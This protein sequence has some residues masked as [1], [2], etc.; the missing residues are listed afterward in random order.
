MFQPVWR[1]HCPGKPSILMLLNPTQL[2]RKIVRW[3]VAVLGATLIL[4]LAAPAA[5]A[6]QSAMQSAEMDEVDSARG[7]PISSIEVAGN[8][9]ISREDVLAYLRERVGQPFSPES[10]AQDTRELWASGF[11]DDIEV[12]LDRSTAGVVLRFNVRERPNIKKVEFVGND[13]VS[14]EDLEEGVELKADTILSQPAIARSIQKIRDMY[15]E[16]GYFL[17]EAES[18]VLP[19]KHNEV[20]VR[21]KISEHSQ[22]SVRRITF[23]GN[24]DIPEKDLRAVMYTGQSNILSFGSG[25]PFRQDAF[26]RDV[27]VINALYYDKGYLTVQIHTPRIMLTPDRS[28][29]ELSITINEGP[30]FKVRQLRIYE[31]GADGREVEPI[32]GRRKLRNRIRAK[33]GDYFNR[34]ELLEDLGSVRTVYRDHGYANVDASPET[35]LHPETNEVDVI[36]PVVRG[37]LV[38]FDRIEVLGNTKTRDKVIRRE[39]EIIE[40]KKF[41]ETLLEDS[42]RRVT[43]LGYF[44][45]V[46]VTTSPGSSPDRLNVQ[47]EVSER[48]TGTFQVG[49]GFSSIEQFIATAQIQQANLMGNG[50]NVSLNAQISRIRRLVNFSLFEPY[51]LDSRIRASV[52]LFNQLRNYQDFTQETLGGSLTWGYPLIEPEL[53]ASITYTLEDNDVST[54]A[55]TSLFGSTIPTSQFRQLPLFNLFDD[56]LT[57]SIRPSVTL[58]TRDNRLFPTSGIFIQASSELSLSAIGADTEFWRNQV[59]GRFYYPVGGGVVLK[60]NTEFG[61]VTSPGSDGVPIFARYFLGG[62]LDVRG[63]GFRSLSPRI[64]LQNSLDPNSS[65]IQ[66]GG[67]ARFGGNLQFYDNLELEFPIVEEVGIRGVVFTDAGNTWNLEGKYCAFDS[68]VPFEENKPC[69][70]FPEDLARLRTSWGFGIRWFSPLGPLRFEYGFPFAPLSYEESSRFEFTIGN[71]F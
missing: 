24:S 30:R 35:R 15:A 45:R 65:P 16:K 53:A 47:V 29:I 41:S 69:F 36:V 32:D 68:G 19:Q 70:N 34:A 59:T 46:D 2:A 13:A 10:L 64:P 6:Q 22:V 39:I 28:G 23:I 20:V 1:T 50:Q 62:I 63:F 40:G 52:N 12:D 57:S 55:T 60:L 44:E 71:F 54:V 17:A 14:T 61:V 21:F 5:R 48:P 9:R 26:E 51:F 8:R 42:R 31:R 4:T 38:Y 49:A 58:D 25:G 3:C 33:S 7:Q 18:E 43:A 27:A 11:F 37:P 66:E 56:G 67:G